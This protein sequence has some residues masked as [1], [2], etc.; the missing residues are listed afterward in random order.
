M[1]GMLKLGRKSGQKSV[2]NSRL[3]PGMMVVGLSGLQ[4][5]LSN[6]SANELKASKMVASVSGGMDAGRPNA[7]LS[8]SA[9]VSTRL[10]AV[11]AMYAAG[12]KFST[13]VNSKSSVPSIQPLIV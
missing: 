2:G 3:K 5:S 6:G 8:S 11:P 13:S 12:M 10:Q 7:S 9:N 1:L 4:S